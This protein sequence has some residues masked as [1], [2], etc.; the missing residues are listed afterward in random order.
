MYGVPAIISN[1]LVDDVMN[2]RNVNMQTI[3]SPSDDE[4]GFITS[5]KAKRYIRSLPK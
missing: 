4:L 5:E 2:E 1:L 3:G